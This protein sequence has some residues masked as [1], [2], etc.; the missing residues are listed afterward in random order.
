M[1]ASL[2]SIAAVGTAALALVL[3]AAPTRAQPVRSPESSTPVTAEAALER[4]AAAALA[5]G[6][7]GFA[8]HASLRVFARTGRL[9][10]LLNV[11]RAH[12]RRYDRDGDPRDLVDAVATYRRFLGGT[13]P[14]APHRRTAE[15][16]L[17]RLEAVTIDPPRVVEVPRRAVTRLGVLCDTLAAEVSIDDGPFRPAPRLSIVTAGVHRVVVRAPEHRPVTREVKV[18]RGGIVALDVRLEPEPAE[19]VIVGADDTAVHIDGQRALLPA[20]EGAALEL[21]PGEHFVAITQTGFHPFSRRIDLRRGTR[22]TLDVDLK[23]TGQRAA[24]IGLLT[25]G[26]IG[27]TVGIVLGAL[28]VDADRNSRDDAAGDFRSASGI[29]GVGGVAVLVAGGTLL[30]LDEPAVPS[31]PTL[32]LAPAI[33]PRQAGA[34]LTARF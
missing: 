9:E 33:G 17:S 29:V 7:Y 34:G 14:D 20:D 28:A 23:A 24:A 3:T 2:G 19:L 30:I 31:A 16:A 12:H 22:E 32:T 8:I 18:G 25:T 26:G 1:R 6:D 21:A 11:A 4:A 13:P 5:A 10:M 15:R 27:L